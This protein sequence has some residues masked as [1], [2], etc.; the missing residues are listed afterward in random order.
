MHPDNDRDDDARR[1]E[2]AS[3]DS[4]RRREAEPGRAADK[5]RAKKAKDPA[6]PTRAKANRP[7]FAP[8]SPELEKLLNPGIA[9]GTAGPGPSTGIRP[10]ADNSKDRRADF[11]AAHTARA[12]TQGF[13]ESPQA[14]YTGS[15]PTPLAGIDPELASALG[16]GPEDAPSLPSPASG[17]GRSAPAGR[18][19]KRPLAPDFITGASATVRALERLLREGRPEFAG[20]PWMPHRPERPEKSEGGRRLIIKSE[21]EPE[22][23][24]PQAIAELVEGVRQHERTQVLLGVTGSGKTFTMAK[25]IEATQRPALILA[26]NKTLAA[27]L[28]GEFKSFFPDNAVEYFVSYY[29]YYQP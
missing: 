22:G 24:Q 21:F 26:P 14:N 17:G 8:T 27:Q 16:F 6:K 12:S 15:E 3:P 10:P 23:D 2:H 20:K 25:V 13:G 4:E 18:G 19:G 28:Y 29:D 11:S 5:K 9:G 1:A 7:D